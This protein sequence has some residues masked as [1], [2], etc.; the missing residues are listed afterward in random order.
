MCFVLMFFPTI[1]Q[2]YGDTGNSYTLDL[3]LQNLFRVQDFSALFGDFA[4]ALYVISM[5]LLTVCSLIT[6]VVNGVNLMPGHTSTTAREYNKISTIAFGGCGV[7][8]L[9]ASLLICISSEGGISQDGLTYLSSMYYMT[10]ASIIQCIL[11]IGT[12]ALVLILWLMR[13]KLKK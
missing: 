2:I 6:L 8:Y 7:L 12:L 10:Y 9:I 5:I 4:S 1:Q 3:S 11:S 13:R